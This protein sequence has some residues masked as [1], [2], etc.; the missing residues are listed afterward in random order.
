MMS[1]TFKYF[2][3]KKRGQISIGT[4]IGRWIFFLSSLSDVETILEIGTWNGLGSSQLIA[5]GVCSNHLKRHD[6]KVYGLE[7]DESLVKIATRNLR[8]YP[9]FSV[10][11]GRII[12]SEHLDLEVLVGNESEWVEQDVKMMQSCPNV[13]S[14]LPLR[15]DLVILD[16]GEFS[17]Y[18]EFNT[19]EN[20]IKKYLILDDTLTRKCRKVLK[21]MEDSDR[22]EV[23]FKSSER[24]GTA[25]IMKTQ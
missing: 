20:R 3:R 21:V 14:T 6:C 1:L 18:A 16:G 8:K 4:D 25:V 9:F 17:T 23:I 7:V 12:E 13:L 11:H 10:V 22:Y 15:F 5:K 2:P 24:N 19:L